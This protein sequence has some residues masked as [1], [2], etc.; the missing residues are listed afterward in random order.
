MEKQSEPSQPTREEQVML[1]IEIEKLTKQVEQLIK[2]IKEHQPKLG[3]EEE[4]AIEEP[5]QTEG[6]GEPMADKENKK[7]KPSIV[8]I[9][10]ES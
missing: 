2:K 9:L 3:S 6:E 7:P 4:K 5:I 1:N 10:E 8:D